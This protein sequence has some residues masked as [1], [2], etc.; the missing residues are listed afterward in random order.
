MVYTQNGSPYNNDKELQLSPTTNE[1]YNIEQKKP[2]AD[3]M[4]YDSSNGE[5]KIR[6]I[7]VMV[8]KMRLMIP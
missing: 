2:D 5:F 4:L 8:I 7:K 1:K 6:P 3:Y